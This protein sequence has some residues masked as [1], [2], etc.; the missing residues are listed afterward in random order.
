[1][2]DSAIADNL[3]Q[4]RTLPAK[5][6][7]GFEPSYPAYSVRFPEHV[8]DLVMG[9][10]GVQYASESENDGTAHSKLLSFGRS[11]SVADASPFP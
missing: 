2:L 7:A 9:V 10:F 6:R 1:M 5:G 8:K 11:T 3:K 4:D